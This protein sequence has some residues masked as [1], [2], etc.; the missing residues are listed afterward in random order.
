MANLIEIEWEGIK[1]TVTALDHFGTRVERDLWAA[2]AR[3][4]R[5][6]VDKQFRK[7]TQYFTHTVEHDHR[8]LTSP[9]QM[10]YVFS[11][12]DPV[13]NMLNTGTP[14]HVIRATNARALAFRTGQRTPK[15]QPGTLLT[16][17]G[18]AAS[19]PLIFRTFVNHPGFRARQWSAILYRLGFDY[20]Y[21]R[22]LHYFDNYLLQFDEY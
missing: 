18:S 15:T 19:G 6:F 7:T 11:V 2:T 22:A 16:N 5:T 1:E 10:E 14:P 17:P 13:W 12:Q 8:V 9:A 3:D 20:L 21:E 4:T